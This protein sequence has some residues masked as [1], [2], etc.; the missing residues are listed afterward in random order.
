MNKIFTTAA[1][2]AN[3]CRQLMEGQKRQ[4]QFD[5]VRRITIQHG[6]ASTDEVNLPSEGAFEQV[7]YNIQY[8]TQ[9]DGTAPFFVRFKSQG[10]GQGQSNDL[11]PIQAIATPG[12]VIAG[13]TAPR[14]G[15]RPFW[16]FY[17]KDDRLTIEWDGRQLVEDIV[18]DIVFTG[19]VYPDG[20]KAGA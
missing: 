8:T 16:H 6:V 18:M 3:Y 5:F 7:G 4:R 11:L 9:Q 12:A 20:P 17:P 14:Y 19:Y 13:Q 15:F 10:D 2:A 1:E